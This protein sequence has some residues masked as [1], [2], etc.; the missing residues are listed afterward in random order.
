AVK[1]MT[2]RHTARVIKAMTQEILME[3]ELTDDRILWY[4]ADNC[5]N[6]VAAF[7]ESLIDITVKILDLD[8]S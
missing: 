5:A 3:F 4:R 6:I 1:E 2:S 7:R 8:D